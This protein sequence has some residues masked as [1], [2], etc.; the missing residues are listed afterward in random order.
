MI[1]SFTQIATLNDF[2][3]TKSHMNT[4]EAIKQK[5]ILIPQHFITSPYANTNN[6]FET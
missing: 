3:Q 5:S 6:C 4:I 2:N 1:Y